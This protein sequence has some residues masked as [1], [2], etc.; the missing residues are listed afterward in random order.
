MFAMYNHKHIRMSDRQNIK[1]VQC[2]FK[3]IEMVKVYKKLK[4]RTSCVSLI[5]FHCEKIMVRL[6]C[7]EVVIAWYDF[8]MKKSC[9][10]GMTLVHSHIFLNF[11]RS[12]ST[13]VY[14]QIVI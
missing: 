14:L 10:L 8:I 3:I 7:E 9:Q 6:Y 4:I 1:I 2:F 13:M 5:R 11:N 12:C